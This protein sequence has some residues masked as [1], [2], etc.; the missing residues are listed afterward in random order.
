MGDTQEP[1]V[2]IANPGTAASVAVSV[3]ASESHSADIAWGL[4]TPVKEHGEE[5]LLACATPGGRAGLHSLAT[6]PPGTPAGDAHFLKEF[7]KAA[8]EATTEVINLHGGPMQYLQQRYTTIESRQEFADALVAHFPRSGEIEYMC[9]KNFPPHKKGAKPIVLHV[10]DFSFSD[11]ASPTMPPSIKTSLQIAEQCLI[12]GFVS[13]G[14]EL[15]V[16]QPHPL[17]R[18][19]LKVSNAL[20]SN[21]LMPQ[22]VGYVKGQARMHTLLT[23]LSLCIDDGVPIYQMHPKLFETV[24]TIYCVFISKANRKEEVFDNF[25]LSNRGSIRKPP[26]C[27]TWVGS[28][29]KLDM[30]GDKA[31]G[32]VVRE[33]NAIAP[34][35]DQIIGLKAQ[36]VKAILELMPSQARCHAYYYH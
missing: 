12:D 28:L 36:S 17:R 23:M 21:Q 29:R 13:D 19:A 22:T 31:T 6:P 24:Q 4:V 5:F 7:N 20:A 30:N 8:F 3:A 9:E 14:D 35:S 26:S 25:K 32:A 16:S 15:K 11:H 27:F 34:K 33:W 2:S 1:D 10:S 18:D